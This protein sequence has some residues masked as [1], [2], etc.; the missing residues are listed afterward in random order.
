MPA[1]GGRIDQGY[2]HRAPSF[3]L[4]KEVVGDIF[5]KA[6]DYSMMLNLGRQIPVGINETII[7]TRGRYPEAG[8]VGGTTLASREGAEKPIQ[9]ISFGSEKAFAPI[10]LAVIVTVSDEFASYNPDQMYSELAGELTG[11]VARA[12]DLA[13]FHNKDAI[14]GTDLIGTSA[15]SYIN[16][17]TNEVELNFLPTASP[18]LVSQIIGGVR[19]VEAEVDGGGLSKNFRVNAFAADREM[20]W[21]LITQR[22]T[23]GQPVFVGAMPSTGR[24]INLNGNIAELFGLPLVYGDSVRGRLGAYAGSNALMF[25]GD[26]SQLAWGFADQIR[27]KVTDTATVGGVSMWQTNQVAVLAECTFGWIVNDP[28]AF[29]RYKNTVTDA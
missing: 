13:V 28:E 19:A 27:V 22:R 26:W 15:S 14:L 4:P 29:V 1:A 8:Q 21:P 12:A 17:T 9:G 25:G 16:A 23:D 2:L 7:R 20:R 3:L 5:T 11:A 10:K 18:D 6:R 24:D